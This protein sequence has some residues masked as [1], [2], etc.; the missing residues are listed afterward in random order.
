MEE[1][2]IIIE[3]KEENNINDDG[4]IELY[5]GIKAEVV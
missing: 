3:P 2:E 1:L 5:P 4:F